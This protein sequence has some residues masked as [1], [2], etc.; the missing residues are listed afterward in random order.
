M[1][2]RVLGEP[3]EQ[4]VIAV[5]MGATPLL[6]GEAGVDD[7]AHHSQR[8][9]RVGPRERAQ[10]L[11]G[12]PRGAAAERVDDARAA[13]PLRRASRIFFHRCGAV[14]IGFQPQTST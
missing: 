10:V 6:V 13:A 1:L 3:L 7:R 11:V 5:G 4:L 2:D 9:R 14:D 12:D 8:Q